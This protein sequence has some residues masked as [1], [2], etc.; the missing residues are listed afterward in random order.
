MSQAKPTF[1]GTWTPVEGVN[2]PVDAVI[3]Q[4]DTL[5]TF[6]A[7]DDPAHH[8]QYR[9]DG[10]ETTQTAGPVR[11]KTQWDGAKLV[12]T[13]SYMAGETVASVTRQ[14]WTLDADGRLVIE[15]IRERNGQPATTKSVYKR[16]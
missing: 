4:T 13:N 5:L 11:S 7:G 8:A 10:V 6:G 16:R 9:L 15:T 1:A 14:V 3:T 12:V 2:P